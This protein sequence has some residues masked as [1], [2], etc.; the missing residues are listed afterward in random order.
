MIKGFSLLGKESNRVFVREEKE[1]LELQLLNRYSVRY[2]KV[3][4]VVRKLYLLN[5]II[6]SQL[7]RS[8]QYEY[9][10]LCKKMQLEFCYLST[11]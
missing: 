5:K 10:H 2:S 4:L 6:L 8:L 7:V 3:N 9:T 11:E 1:T